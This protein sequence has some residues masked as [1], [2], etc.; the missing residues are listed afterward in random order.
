MSIMQRLCDRD[1]N[2]A[3]SRFCKDG[4]R[5]KFGEEMNRFIAEGHCRTWAGV[6]R[7]ATLPQ[8]PPD[9]QAT[10]GP[11]RLPNLF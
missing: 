6:I 4:F 7:P 1:I 8:V 9:T 10:C 5:V 11:K 3:V 2:V